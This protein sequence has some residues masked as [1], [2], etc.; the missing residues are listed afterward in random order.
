MFKIHR[1]IIFKMTGLATHRRWHA[2]S[3]NVETSCPFPARGNQGRKQG[4]GSA[5]DPPRA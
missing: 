1:K 4:E 2:I 5:L 3:D